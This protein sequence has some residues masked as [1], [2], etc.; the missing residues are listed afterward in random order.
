MEALIDTFVFLALLGMVLAF[1]GFFMGNL[2]YT[3]LL[4]RVNKGLVTELVDA[5]ESNKRL[6]AAVSPILKQ[7][8]GGEVVTQAGQNTLVQAIKVKPL[9]WSEQRAKLEA[10]IPA[11]EERAARVQE[12]QNSGG[13]A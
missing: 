6:S 3:R 13:T 2:R 1:C 5:R 12:Y 7:A 9:R 10:Q 8:F 11:E 4:E